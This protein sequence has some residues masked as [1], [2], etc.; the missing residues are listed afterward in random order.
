MKKEDLKVRNRYKIEIL[1]PE[2]S[3]FIQRMMIDYGFVWGAG[4]TDIKN[5]RYK[6]LVF[7]MNSLQI[8][9][10][11]SYSETDETNMIKTD[12]LMSL[13]L[14]KSVVSHKVKLNDDNDAIINTE[15]STFSVGCQTFDITVAQEITDR[16]N[17]L[18]G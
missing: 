9:H 15:E 18:K 16:Y 7:Y 2:H 1:N 5:T 14:G 8:L 13:F 6:Y 4:T 10:A 17:Q 11:G 12:E 3:A